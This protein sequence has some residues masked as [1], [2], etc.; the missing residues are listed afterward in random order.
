MY[1]ERTNL[2]DLDAI[3]VKES[4]VNGVV[5]VAKEVA[6]DSFKFSYELDK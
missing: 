1:D 2:K 4:K 3:I 6:K 5:Q